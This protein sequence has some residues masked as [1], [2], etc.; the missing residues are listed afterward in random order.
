MK[1]GSAFTKEGNAPSNVENGFLK[2][3]SALTKEGN[4]LTKGQNARS[5]E[6]DG[7]P[8]D[9]SEQTTGEKPPGRQVRQ[10]KRRG[11]IEGSLFAHGVPGVLAVNLS[12]FGGFPRVP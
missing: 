1:E 10:G 7:L 8:D 2:E 5:R 3:G 11:L 12:L 4:A 9:K 6:G